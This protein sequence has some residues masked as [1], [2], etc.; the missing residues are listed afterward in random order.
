[1][2]GLLGN[3]LE[4]NC[5]FLS[6]WE[7]TKNKGQF[8]N[9]KKKEKRGACK[10]INTL[11]KRNFSERT[12]NFN[13]KI[14]KINKIKYTHVRIRANKCFKFR[15]PPPQLLDSEEKKLKLKKRRELLI[16]IMTF[17][18]VPEVM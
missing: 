7:I 4:R 17:K 2:C 12:K 6:Q 3:F 13:L 14:N 8:G 15:T 11:G 18:L 10:N 16:K 5:W 1:L 9:P